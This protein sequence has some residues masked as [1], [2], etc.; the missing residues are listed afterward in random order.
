MDT[1]SLNNSADVGN[2]TSNSSTASEI[3]IRSTQINLPSYPG[4]QLPTSRNIDTSGSSQSSNGSQRVRIK[5]KYLREVPSPFDNADNAV[6]E[7][8][9]PPALVRAATPKDPTLDRRVSPVD[10]ERRSPTERASPVDNRLR[11]P[12]IDQPVSYAVS[13]GRNVYANE[14]GHHRPNI[15]GASDSVLVQGRQ[16]Q[17]QLF[18]WQP[19]SDTTVVKITKYEPGQRRKVI[20]ESLGKKQ[21]SKAPIKRYIQPNFVNPK[22]TGSE[23]DGAAKVANDVTTVAA[24]TAAAV[25]AT[26]PFLKSQSDLEIKINGILEKLN[27]LKN[28]VIKEQPSS[29]TDNDIERR[30]HE[31]ADVRLQQMERIQQQQLEWQTRLMTQMPTNVDHNQNYYTNTEPSTQSHRYPAPNIHSAITVPSH[32]N[33][34][35]SRDYMV[36]DNQPPPVVKYQLATP[37]PEPTK[38]TMIRNTHSTQTSPLDTPAPRRRPPLPISKD[39]QPRTS[40]GLLEEILRKDAV[41][42]DSVQEINE[43]KDG[44]PQLN[45]NKYMQKSQEVPL[46]I[47]PNVTTDMQ[48]RDMINELHELKTE[49][50]TAIQDTRKIELIGQQR[51]HVGVRK[52]PGGSLREAARRQYDRWE[53]ALDGPAPLEKYLK[54]RDE[55]KKTHGPSAPSPV[56]YNDNDNV[57]PPSCAQ[58]Q[59]LLEMVQGQRANLE[60]NLQMVLRGRQEEEAYTF[61]ENLYK[62]GSMKEQA[63]I[64]RAVDQ[65]IEALNKEIQRELSLERVKGSDLVTKDVHPSLSKRPPKSLHKP[66]LEKRGTTGAARPNK[67]KARS[68]IDSGLR[69]SSK[70]DV[71][72][73]KQIKK[74]SAKEKENRPIEKKA[75]SPPPQIPFYKDEDYLTRVYGKAQHSPK[76]RTLKSGPYLRYRSSPPRP[77][78][79]RPS[80]VQDIPSSRPKSIKTKQEQQR[81][82]FQKTPDHQFYFDPSFQTALPQ[83]G[84]SNQGLG[85]PI[86]G[87]LIP[88]AIP[89][90]QPRTSG[91]DVPL[92]IYRRRDDDDEEEDDDDNENGHLDGGVHDSNPNILYSEFESERKTKPQ[93]KIQTM[94]HIDIQPG[95]TTQRE[96]IQITEQHEDGKEEEH[97]FENE[98]HSEQ[99]QN[100]IAVEEIREDDSIDELPIPQIAFAGQP[101]PET[102]YTGPPFPPEP[103]PQLTE[104]LPSS[105]IASDIKRRELLH[106]QAV[107]WIE[108]ELMARMVSDMYHRQED[109]EQ[110]QEEEDTASDISS[111]DAI[112]DAISGAAGL[113]LFVDARQPVNQELV[114]NLIKE[115]IAERIA[116][117]LSQQEVER[118]SVKEVIQVDE[119]SDIEQEPVAAPIATPE[120]TPVHTP[121]ASPPVKRSLPSTPIATPTP[122][123]NESMQEELIK[124]LPRQMTPLED[125]LEVTIAGPL[126]PVTTPVQTPPPSPPAFPATPEVSLQ[127][128]ESPE[129]ESP[130]KSTIPMSLKEAA[131]PEPWTDDPP[132][133]EEKMLEQIGGINPDKSA[134]EFEISQ[135]ILVPLTPVPATPLKELP[136]TPPVYQ[137][138]DMSESSESTQEHTSTETTDRPISE[139]EWLTG[140]SQGEVIPR[141][142]LPYTSSSEDTIL[143]TEEMED[144]TM[145]EPPSEGEVLLK[146]VHFQQDPVLALLAKINQPTSEAHQ[147]TMDSELSIG[148]VAFRKRNLPSSVTGRLPTA[149]QQSDSETEA[150]EVRKRMNDGSSPGEVIPTRRPLEIDDFTMRMSDLKPSKSK[151]LPSTK[152][153]QPEDE[154]PLDQESDVSSFSKEKP[155]KIPVA[156]PRVIQ[157][158]SKAKSPEP[159]MTK[160]QRKKSSNVEEIFEKEPPQQV[161]NFGGTQTLSDFGTRTLTPDALNMDAYLQSGY[162]SQTFSQSEAAT[163]DFEQT[164]NLIGQNTLNNGTLN[165]SID[166]LEMSRDRSQTMEKGT[167]KFMVTLPTAHEL[168][169]SMSQ[170]DVEVYKDD[171]DEISDVSEIF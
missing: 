98:G 20:K 79:T 142:D 96:E 89:L 68:K 29:K 137:S 61:I 59:A 37:I 54:Q 145:D 5:A 94:P 151:V 148:E 124:S 30:L 159:P 171:G 106:N 45:H 156:R 170:S 139:G 32:L 116:A 23:S 87:Q 164:G 121:I 41:G 51:S 119:E 108:Q 55:H 129:A 64:K 60:A 28:P 131:S 165:M 117:T 136:D 21:D 33:P 80:A 10:R 66:P 144:L 44:S 115:A 63:H 90:M 134:Q 160:D 17:H 103:P 49:M 143:Q 107:Q 74:T 42:N 8:S 22:S 102:H 58:A 111:Q 135:D 110:S 105:T 3:L 140:R 76:R 12:L 81:A 43:S 161:A 128:L 132:L 88:M 166:S 39:L 73:T 114:L 71:V 109:N 19:Q 152:I 157:V 67:K 138:P 158:T 34:T 13:S 97:S 91:T 113:Q 82:L 150:G 40:R 75:R 25:A 6:E 101:H 70:K 53:R 86:H 9:I 162:L 104:D 92:S 95:R 154:Q 112:V 50:Q 147:S 48:A 36:P 65:R 125:D 46:I 168:E 133:A 69:K 24:M 120:I 153:T 77:K 123:E 47:Q 127:P 85:A 7:L 1:L 27:S 56:R 4:H 100:Y 38:K 149:R 146:K 93:L 122:S 78:V 130:L 15:K 141:K 163:T 72:E 52:S 167:R 35:G 18:T 155:S 31:M 99:F 2:Q 84:T 26:A 11:V 118:S 14:G 83:P 16:N 169:A 126:S 57:I 62:D